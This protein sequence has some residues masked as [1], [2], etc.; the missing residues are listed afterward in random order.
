[1]GSVSAVSPLRRRESVSGV[2]EKCNQEIFTNG[3][4]AF[5]FEIRC[6]IGSDTLDFLP[7]DDETD[8]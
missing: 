6:E 8:S 4:R 5:P 2:Y 7:D 1:M 3:Q